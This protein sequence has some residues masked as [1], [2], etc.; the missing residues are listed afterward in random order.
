M[1]NLEE[2]YKKY[3]SKNGGGDKGNLHDYLGTYEKHLTKRSNIDFVEI[4]VWRG[5]SLMMWNEYF[6]DSRVYGIDVRMD[7]I[8]YPELSN[9]YL[10][11][12]REKDQVDSLFEET[13]FDY[14]IDDGSHYWQ[15]Q[16]QAFNIFY[17][18]L[19]TP[20]KY[21][22]EDILGDENL[23][24]LINHVSTYTDN[25]EVVDTRR[26]DTTFCDLIL[27]VENK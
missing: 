7:L 4:G 2:I 17:P 16:I 1:K 19:K 3:A 21:F 20:G 8:T 14:I 13:S 24:R 11:D 25:Y 6:S 26:P 18:R 27:I 22:I 5:D 23:E 12:A 9:A 10:C 15:H